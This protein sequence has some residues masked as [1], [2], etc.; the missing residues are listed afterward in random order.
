MRSLAALLITL[1]IATATATPANASFI[2]AQ[3]LYESCEEFS[4]FCFGYLAG[5]YDGLARQLLERPNGFCIAADVGLR[6]LRDAYTEFARNRPTELNADGAVVLAR[7]LITRFPCQAGQ[8]QQ[9][10]TQ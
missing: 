8:I 7:A 9:Q 10:P 5:A 3:Q 6:D 2:R 4:E 1:G